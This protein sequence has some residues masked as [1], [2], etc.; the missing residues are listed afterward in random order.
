[1]QDIF[2]ETHELNVRHAIFRLTQCMSILHMV[3]FITVLLT[4]PLNLSTVRALIKFVAVP[5][6]LVD[7]FKL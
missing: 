5:S 4:L 1:M 7:T 2:C 6:M 3:T